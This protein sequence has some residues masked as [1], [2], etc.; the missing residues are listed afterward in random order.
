MEEKAELERRDNDKV[1]R[2]AAASTGLNLFENFT[3]RDIFHS[4]LDF[5]LAVSYDAHGILVLG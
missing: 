3:Q 5:V 1:S 4:K 2:N